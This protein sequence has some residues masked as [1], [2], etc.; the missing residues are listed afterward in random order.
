MDPVVFVIVVAIAVPAAF[1]LGVVF[2]KYVVSEAE[3]VKAH[4]TAEIQEVRADLSSLLSKL[5]G[6]V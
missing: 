6:K 1:A 4:M 2:H 5:A 3:K